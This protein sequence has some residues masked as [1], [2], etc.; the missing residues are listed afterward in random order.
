MK[1]L[2]ARATLPIGVIA[3][4][5]CRRRRQRIEESEVRDPPKVGGI[6]CDEGEV[7]HERGRRDERVAQAHASPRPMRRCWRSETAWSSIAWSL[8]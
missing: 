1:H 6:P 5:G 4:S 8:W 2:H 7:V 3:E